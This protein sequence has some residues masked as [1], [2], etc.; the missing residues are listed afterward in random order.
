MAL[1]FHP[2]TEIERDAWAGASETAFLAE[3][4]R[5]VYMVCGPDHDDPHWTANVQLD[6]GSVYHASA[7]TQLAAMTLC[8]V[9]ADQGRGNHDLL[10]GIGFEQVVD[11]W[12][13]GGR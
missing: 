2:M 13:A 11:A 3:D 9:A 7:S 10:V 1:T 12:D 6:D 4:D 8:C 5:G